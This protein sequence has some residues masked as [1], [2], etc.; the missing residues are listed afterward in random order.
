M[1]LR[2]FLFYPLSRNFSFFFIFLHALFW[3]T[4][5]HD[6]S[7]LY[8]TH[9]VACDICPKGFHCTNT[10]TA[11]C[12]LG[13]YCPVGEHALLP[14][15]TLP[16]IVSSPS[17]CAL[18]VCF[19]DWH[20]ELIYWWDAIECF[21]WDKYALT[22]YLFVCLFVSLSDCFIWLVYLG[23]GVFPTPCPT[24]RYGNTTGLEAEDSCHICDAGRFCSATG[25]SRPDGSCTAGYYCPEG[26][27]LSWPYECSVN[28]KR[29]SHL[30]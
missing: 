17:R 5:S 9:A 10:A 1:K 21:K 4:K 25:L 3:W 30:Y 14:S 19:P 29:Y 12:P 11:I 13:H 7:K 15:F 26:T 18:R 6:L 16:F 28:W 24:G 23:T 22:H 8:R 2:Y 27:L 20:D